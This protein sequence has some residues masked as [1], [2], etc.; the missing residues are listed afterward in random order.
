MGLLSSIT[1]YKMKHIT[2]KKFI[3]HMFFWFLVIFALITAEPIYNLLYSSGL[4]N[5]E[6]LSLFDVIQITAIIILFYG[7]NR[8][9]IKINKIE[10][11]FEDIHSEISI[12][13][14]LTK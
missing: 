13:M 7:L 4:T 12:S 1:Q 9:R 8:A 11:K 10:R 2:L 3:A 5:T 6:S 14:S